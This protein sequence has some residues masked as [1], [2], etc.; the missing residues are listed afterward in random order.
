MAKG[1]VIAKQ[2]IVMENT[3]AIQFALAVLQEKVG[4]V[5]PI[6][7]ISKITIT[8]GVITLTVKEQTN[9]F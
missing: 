2:E 6:E 5:C 7:L 4:R 1:K 9:E 8:D 3:A